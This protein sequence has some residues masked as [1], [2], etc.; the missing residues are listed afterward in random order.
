MDNN[1]SQFV[2]YKCGR[3]SVNISKTIVNDVIEAIQKLSWE[4]TPEAKDN[5]NDSDI[6]KALAQ[7]QKQIN[8]L[9]GGK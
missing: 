4:A 5:N 3:N 2:N 9:K 7:L 1:G 6:V 8:S